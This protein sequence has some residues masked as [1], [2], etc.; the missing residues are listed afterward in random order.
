VKQKN[1][2]DAKAIVYIGAKELLA[3]GQVGSGADLCKLLL[4][5]YAESATPVHDETVSK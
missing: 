2:S 4:E 5:L 1:Y 3:A